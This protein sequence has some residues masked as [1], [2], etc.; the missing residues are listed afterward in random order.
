MLVSARGFEFR[1]H[2][3]GPDAGPPVLLLHGFPQHS[4]QWHKVVPALHA[5]GLRTIA[6]DQRGYSP[7]A[8]PVEIADY[9]LA[10]MTKDAFSI[11]DALG[12]GA[13]HVVGHDW[14]AAVAW[15]MAGTDPRRLL[16]LTTI[17][18]P[19]LAAMAVAMADEQSDQRERSAYMGF[20]AQLDEAVSA[21]LADDAQLLKSLFQGSGMT[22]AEV[23]RYVAPMRDPDALRGG[24]S[25]YTAVLTQPRQKYGP[26]TVPTTFIWSTEDV[27]LGPAAAHACGRFVTA[28]YRYVELEGVSHW[29]PDQDPGAVAAA[30]L[31]RV[32]RGVPA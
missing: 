20:F 23:E 14:G 25:W 28:D 32:T 6:V 7:G 5:A 1:V 13:C 15:S 9:A 18:V 24:L 22:E 30:I 8:R 29:V 26:V 2:A 19:H 16:T 10:E 21:L 27:A 11:M 31:D 12:L 4:G 17:S 3:A